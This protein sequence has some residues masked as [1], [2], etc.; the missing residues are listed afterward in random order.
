M[1][2]TVAQVRLER[3][4]APLDTHRADGPVVRLTVIRVTD[5]RQGPSAVTV[6]QSSEVTGDRSTVNGERSVPCTGAVHGVLDGTLVSFFCGGHGRGRVVGVDKTRVELRV[7]AGQRVGVL[8]VAHIECRD[9]RLDH[10]GHEELRACANEEDDPGD[11]K[12]LVHVTVENGAP[13]GAE[14]EGV[15][16]PT[17]EAAHHEDRTDHVL[18]HEHVNAAAH[19]K[20]P[21]VTRGGGE[22]LAVE[23]HV[24]EGVLV[25]EAHE[26]VQEA[27]RAQ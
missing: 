14:E 4:T 12:P 25:E 7:D 18:L 9:C 22:V 23:G 27:Q 17:D 20:C 26:H 21:R 3:V 19:E 16:E 6:C 13:P 1:R 10:R 15:G 24:S 5:S 11:R 2:V 8:R